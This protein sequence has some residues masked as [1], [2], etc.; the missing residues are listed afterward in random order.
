LR[1]EP[2]R[3]S[4][5]DR[6]FINITKPADDRQLRMD[7]LDLQPYLMQKLVQFACAVVRSAM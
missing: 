4:R 5:H 3:P 6:R 2:R 7:F 1:L